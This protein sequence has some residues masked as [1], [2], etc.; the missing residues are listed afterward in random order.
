MSALF[1]TFARRRPEFS[2]AVVSEWSRIEHMW[3]DAMGEAWNLTDPSGSVFL[4]RA[5]VRGLGMPSHEPYV[6]TSPAIPGQRHVGSRVLP[7]EAFWP[8]YLYSD[9]GSDAFANVDRAFW[10]GMHRDRHGLWR[11]KV[12]SQVRELA[13]RFAEA[14]DAYERDPVHFGSATYGVRLIADDPF[15][16]GEWVSRRFVNADGNATFFG[17]GGTPFTIGSSNTID[18]STIDNPGDEKSY[19]IYILNGP[20]TSASVGIGSAN[21]VQTNYV[22]DVPEGKSVVV[23]TRPAARA[24]ARLIDTPTATVGAEDWDAQVFGDPGV[25][26]FENLTHI[27]LSSPLQAGE[28]RQLHLALAGAGSVTVAHRPPYW[29]AW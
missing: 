7:R 26:V 11:V 15:W 3:I 27:A 8:L 12:G 25:N 20:F 10:R 17:S 19:L 1:Q 13:C 6:R 16:Y 14:E 18:T 2:G 4:R 9:E 24:T 21:A 29:R 23:D 5:G 28:N 22:G